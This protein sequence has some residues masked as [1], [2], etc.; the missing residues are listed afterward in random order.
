[1][2]CQPHYH[3]SSA[4]N[5]TGNKR[6]SDLVLTRWWVCTAMT[7]GVLPAPGTTGLRRLRH[8]ELEPDDDDNDEDND[9]DDDELEAEPSGAMIGRDIS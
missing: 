5:K 7:R 1:V 4:L 2:I 9:D 8:G 3:T 6:D